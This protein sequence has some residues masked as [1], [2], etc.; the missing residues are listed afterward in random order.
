LL[1][2]ERI[3]ADPGLSGGEATGPASSPRLRRGA[4]TARREPGLA[5]GG[6]S[7]AGTRGDH[8]QA[9]KSHFSGKC[10]FSTRKRVISAGKPPGWVGN[11]GFPAKLGPEG[12][13]RPEKSGIWAN[14][15]EKPR[16]R[17]V[18]F[19]I[20]PIRTEKP[21]NFVSGTPPG[22]SGGPPREGSG[23][24][25]GRFSAHKWQISTRNPLAGGFRA[26]IRHF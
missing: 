13:N 26:G 6:W 4:A 23:L 1:F 8:F 24:K 17:G 15:Q 12:E 2:R 21:P 20:G 19:K 9:G 18:F 7:E 16:P 10:H 3:T 22:G 11:S 5:S 25:S 14:F